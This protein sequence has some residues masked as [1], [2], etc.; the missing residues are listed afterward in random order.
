MLSLF[1]VSFPVAVREYPDKRNLIEKKFII[2]YCS[3]L[4]PIIVEKPTVAGAADRHSHCIQNQESESNECKFE[5]QFTFSTLYVP[6][7][8]AQGMV[9]PITEM[10]LLNQLT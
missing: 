5:A 3:G 1:S 9:P 6:G 2:G 4:Q 8:P 10:S 7:S